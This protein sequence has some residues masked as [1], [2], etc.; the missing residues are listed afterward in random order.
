MLLIKKLIGLGTSFSLSAFFVCIFVI[1]QN[2]LWNLFWLK[3][4]NFDISF[5]VIFSSLIH[6]IKGGSSPIILQW[7]IPISPVSYTHLTLPTK[8]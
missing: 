2:T 3:T 6:D 5:L 1:S 7:G 8:A 4:Q